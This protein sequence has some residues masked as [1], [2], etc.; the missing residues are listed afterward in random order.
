MVNS[1]DNSTVQTVYSEDGGSLLKN[2]DVLSKLSLDIK[3]VN[4]TDTNPEKTHL[5]GAP[6]FRE[7]DKVNI[8]LHLV[9]RFFL[10]FRSTACF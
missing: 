9:F 4:K 5:Q 7:A 6:F 1:Q 3:D 10:L 2:R 8:S